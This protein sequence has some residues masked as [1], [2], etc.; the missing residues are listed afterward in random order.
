MLLTIGNSDRAREYQRISA[1]ISEYQ[2]VFWLLS[3][4]GN[5]QKPR[6]CAGK[7]RSC[8]LFFP[9]NN[10]Q[11]EN[12]RS[13]KKLALENQPRYRVVP[14]CRRMTRGTIM[15]FAIQH[16]HVKTKDPK[17]TMQFYIDNLGATYVAEIP[18][19]GHRV[20]LHGLTLNITTLISTQN[21]EQHYGIEHIALDTDDYSG[22]MAKLRENGV[23]VLEELP[24]NNG[25]RVCFLEAPDGAQIELIE[26]VARP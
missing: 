7:G 21:H 24:P 17:Q 8:S 23:R 14:R 16:V 9:R 5:L 10:S 4:R 19:R 12:A 2:P 22:T 20:N 26:K 11:L 25:R 15:S 6:I 18:G 13:R 3:R 1:N